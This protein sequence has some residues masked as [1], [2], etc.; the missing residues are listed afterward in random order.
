MKAIQFYRLL[1][2]KLQAYFAFFIKLG[3]DTSSPFKKHI[4]SA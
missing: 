1:T 4:Q 2:R 3:N